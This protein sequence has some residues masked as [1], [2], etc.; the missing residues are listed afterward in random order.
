MADVFDL[1]VKDNRTIQFKFTEPIMLEDNHVTDW[2]FHIPR[3]LNNLDVSGWAW[4]LVHINARG[5]K[6][7]EL[8]T[9]SEDPESPL[10]KCV[11]TY[12][13]DY[14]MSIRAGVVR[15]SLE[16]INADTSGTI[17]NEWHTQTYQAKVQDTLQ[18]NQ[19]EFAETE[20]DIISALIIEVQNKMRQL[21]GGATPLPVNLKSLMIDHDKVY[22]YTGSETG[23]STG[24]W[25][26]WNGTDF[27]PGGLYGAGVQIDSTLS[28]SGQ[29]A[30]A[31]VVG[32]DFYNITGCER[33]QVTAEKKYINL[34]GTSVVMSDGTPQITENSSSYDLTLVPCAAGDIFTINGTGGTSPRLWGFVSSTG[35]ILAVANASA[36]A[37]ELVLQAPESSAWLIVNDNSNSA[38]YKGELTKKSIQ[39]LEDLTEKAESVAVTDGI[40]GEYAGVTFSNSNGKLKMSGT[41]STGRR[42]LFLGGQFASKILSSAFEKTL[43]AGTYVFETDL[44]GYSSGINYSI[45]ATYTTFKN[46]FFVV[47]SNEG[48]KAVVTFAEPVM[49]GFIISDNRNFGT[50]DNP[51]YLSCIVKKVTAIDY[52]ARQ[53][54]NGIEDTLDRVIDVN[55]YDLQLINADGTMNGVTIAWTSE[56]EATITTSGESSTGVFFN[57]ITSGQTVESGDKIAIQFDNGGSPDVRIEM[58]ARES[59]SDSWGSSTKFSSSG[60][61]TVPSGKNQLLSRVYIPSNKS[62]NTNIKIKLIRCGIGSGENYYEFVT[63]EN[64]YNVTATPTITTDTNNYLASTGDTTDRTSDIITLLNTTGMCKLGTGKFYVN[65]LVMP[66]STTISGS[67]IATEI[68]RAG[69]DDGFAIQ[70]KSYCLVENCLISG[71]VSDITLP[72]NVGNR[73]GILWAGNYTQDPTAGNQPRQGII[74]NVWVKSFT[75]GA[76]TCYDTGYGTFNN[77]EVANVQIRNCGCGINI[78]YWSEFHKFTNVRTYGCLY[79]CINNGGNNLFVNCDFSAC[80]HGLLMDNSQ[81]QSPNNSHG[82]MIGC[83]FNHTNNNTGIGIKILNCDNGFIFTGCQIFFSQIDIEDSDGVVISDTN[84][85]N[86]NCDIAISGGGVVLFANN[87]H[88][89][90]P[91]INI[92]DNNNVHFV[93]CYVRSTGV[94]VTP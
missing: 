69:S 52:V 1:Y 31:K 11:A 75:G 88:N 17:L 12:T 6:Y 58:Y 77:L 46:E 54:V 67:G 83:V 21:V 89:G 23:E 20:S 32:D 41:C 50:E 37:T 15:F 2:V 63:N 64:T 34:A 29:A 92:T 55:N 79:G 68:I 26:N 39:R 51:T 5:Q 81:S 76:I 90:T 71:S 49:I 47:N 61:Y 35:Q 78:P 59:G 56:D 48:K 19:V 91:T 57:N 14:S 66:P 8:L 80:T 45:R 9:L 44:T 87:M 18:G 73:H 40:S 3:I 7:S 84:F 10:D 33:L 30:D 82:S 28:Q 36:T 38:S 72:N 13:V 74:S 22:L 60:F 25:Y 93:N 16:A 4:W 65:D 70:M 27:V 53:E 42:I 94:A 24:Y 86:T 62:V 85:G 43:D